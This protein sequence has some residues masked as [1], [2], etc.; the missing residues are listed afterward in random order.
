MEMEGHE[1][2]SHTEKCGDEESSEDSQ[3]REN[4][5]SLARG[6]EKHD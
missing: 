4:L 2:R 6:R 5:Y 1:H 3:D